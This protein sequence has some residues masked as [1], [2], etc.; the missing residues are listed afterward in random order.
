MI[1]PAQTGVAIE[2]KAYWQHTGEIVSS[3]RASAAL[4]ELGVAFERITKRFGER[5]E[6][7]EFCKFHAHDPGEDEANEA[8][9]ELRGRI[10]S[11]AGQPPSNVFLCPSGMQAIHAALRLSRA[12]R[13]EQHKPG[14]AAVVFGF[15]YLDTLKMCGRK[16]LSDGVEFFGFGDARDL[17][18]LKFLLKSRAAASKTK[19]AGITCLM[20][21][22]PSNPL[23]N[24][25]DLLKLRSLA[26]EYNFLLIVDDTIGNFANVDLLK[27]GVADV[28]CT[29][30]TK[31]F[32]G[33]GDAIAGSVVVSEGGARSEELIRLMKEL[34]GGNDGDLWASDAR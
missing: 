24:I 32:N 28:I 1:F 7:M 4:Q 29:S 17:N 3:R 14:G 31:L 27:S 5:G 9:Q 23:L 25:P 18:T 20:T 8:F 10:G 16:E 21:E 2:A 34:H 22:F 15:P 6:E 11:V 30:L 19:D 26:D 33:R 13:H 12:L